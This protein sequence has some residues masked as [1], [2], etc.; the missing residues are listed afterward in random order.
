MAR[1]LKVVF[2]TDVRGIAQ[3]GDLKTVSPGYARNF[4]F[5]RNL[6]FPAT[7]SALRQWETERQGWIAKAAHLRQDAQDLAQ[8]VEAARVKITA[9][10]SPEGRLF[11]SVNRQEI[12]EALSKQGI[13]I[14]KRWIELPEAIKQLGITSVPVRLHAGIQAQIKVEVVAEPV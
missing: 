4:L 5:P 13:T 12:A 2:R 3:A 9:K 1:T 10:A 8:K 14:D 11:G 6:A 7:P